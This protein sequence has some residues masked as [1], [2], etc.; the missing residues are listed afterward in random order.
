MLRDGDEPASTPKSRNLGV[1]QK[2]NVARGLQRRTVTG[3][4]IV[5]P[6]CLLN[7]NTTEYTPTSG[8]TYG[9]WP[10]V[11]IITLSKTYQLQEIRFKTYDHDPRACR[12]IVSTSVDGK[13][14]TVAADHSKVLCPSGWQRITFPPRPARL[15]KLDGLYENENDKFHVVQLEAY[16]TPQPPPD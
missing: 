9:R 8:Y 1:V 5:R 6:E 2:G 4:K 3:D 7:G 15:I 11:W 12:Y 13:T 14:F 10:F 16:C